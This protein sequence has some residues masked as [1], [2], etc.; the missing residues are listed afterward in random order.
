MLNSS[1]HVWLFA[2]LWTVSLCRRDS[3]VTNTAMRCHVLLQGIFSTQRLDVRLHWPSDSLPLVPSGKLY[4]VSEF[5]TIFSLKKEI[6]LL[7]WW[8]KK[9]NIIILMHIYL[10]KT[11]VRLWSHFSLNYDVV[12]WCHQQFSKHS[13]YIT[14]VKLSNT[15]DKE[16]FQCPEN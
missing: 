15:Y 6:E 1:I 9:K 7:L 8:K 12:L 14:N 2:T 10:N 11:Y 13:D 3:S 4:I 5:P 16:H